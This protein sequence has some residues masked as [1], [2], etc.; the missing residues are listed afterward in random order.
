MMALGG[1]H[2][3][4]LASEMWTGRLPA[5]LV[6]QYASRRSASN[7]RPS[8][9]ACSVLSP[10]KVVCCSPKTQIRASRTVVKATP[11]FQTRRLRMRR[12]SRSI[13][14]TYGH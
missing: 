2:Q 4:S 12:V 6:T 5:M 1:M 14:G 10:L 7:F 13:V 11:A 9:S 3:R 8:S